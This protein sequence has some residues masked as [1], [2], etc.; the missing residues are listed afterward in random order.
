MRRSGANLLAGLAATLVGAAGAA[1]Q[2]PIDEGT[3]RLVVDG[4]EVG[5]ERF[6]I[7]ARG[8]GASEETTATG[9]VT[10][11]D[12]AGQARTTSV[13]FS[14][15]DLRPAQY[16]VSVGGEGGDRLSGRVA[17]RRV[18]ARIVSS[19]GENVREYLV[20]EGAIIL[21][22]MVAHQHYFLARRVRA[23]ETHV[24]VIVPRDARQS[25]IDVEILPNET[26]TVAGTPIDCRKLRLSGEPGGVRLLWT[27]DA[28]RVIRFEIPDRKFVAER[29]ALPK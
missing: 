7:Q 20:S 27:D 22:G 5:T 16:T 28:D 1:A 14:G 9:S 15:L 21:D 3:F 12:A 24:P 17:G 4:R 19:T 6:V 10:L 8:S 2:A 25:W 11:D 23:G 18:S 29:T 13:Q 26:I